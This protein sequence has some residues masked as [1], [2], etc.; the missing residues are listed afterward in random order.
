MNAFDQDSR[1]RYFSPRINRLSYLIRWVCF[2][3]GAFVASQLMDTSHVIL[4][5]S[6][7]V[8]LFSLFVGLFRWVLIPRLHDMGVEPAWAWSLLFFVHSVN[9]LFLLA[10]LLVPTDAFA[11]RRYVVLTTM[12]RRVGRRKR[13]TS[14]SYA[15][16][17]DCGVHRSHRL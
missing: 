16:V 3:I 9:V 17:P 14:A 8:L 13:F 1:T 4:T 7:V 15:S 12:G 2:L 10:L 11:K 6:G 5:A